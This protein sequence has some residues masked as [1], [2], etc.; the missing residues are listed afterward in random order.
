MS[1]T[2]AQSKALPAWLPL[3]ALAGLVLGLGALFAG[4][5][6]VLM[7]AIALAVS[8]VGAQKLPVEWLLARQGAQP[9][10]AWR[11]PQLHQ[12]LHQ[13]ARRAGLQAVPRLFISPSPQPTAFTAGQERAIIVVSAGLLRSLS[14]SEIAGVLAHEVAH[15]RN[16]DTRLLQ[17]ASAFNVV[18]QGLARAA[19][20]ALLLSLVLMLFGN[21]QVP[22]LAFAVMMLG[23]WLGRLLQ[24]SLSRSREYEADATAA[25]LTGDPRG[26]A[27]A[28][29]RLEAM[30]AGLLG[31]LFGLQSALVPQWLRTHPPTAERV[32]R[33]VQPL[34]VTFAP[35][36]YPRRAVP[37]FRLTR[38]YTPLHPRFSD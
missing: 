15:I 1:G 9:L 28:L 14:A 12:T 8:L 37:R 2:Q 30:Q 20:L 11:A 3:A 17:V 36:G 13:L 18:L 4:A 6:G 22:L 29:M 38:S 21:S 31:R 16:A 19:Q 10:P 7:A 25:R 35:A 26:L 24:L 27:S 23:P 32:R 5:L 34:G 33:L